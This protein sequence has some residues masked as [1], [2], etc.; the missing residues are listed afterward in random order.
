MGQLTIEAVNYAT[1]PSYTTSM[2]RQPDYPDYET[3]N[4][5]LTSPGEHITGAASISFNHPNVA[6]QTYSAL[7][8]GNLGYDL[9]DLG[10]INSF[11]SAYLYLRV[12]NRTST[13]FF[14]TDAAGGAALVGQNEASRG[15]VDKSINDYLAIYQARGTEFSTRIPWSSIT[16][17][18]IH[19][20]TMNFNASGMSYL[21]SVFTKPYFKG[22][23]Y[24]GLIFGG[25]VDGVSPTVPTTYSCY[26]TAF[27]VLNADLVLNWSGNTG[28]YIN[29]GDS[30]KEVAG[31]LINIG[32]EWKGIDDIDLN[33]G[34]VWKN[35]A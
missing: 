6:T 27:E 19:Y 13:N 24:F 29:I 7:R 26:Q 23:A 25:I 12:R 28:H 32:D 35:K 17:T 15:G 22:Y 16:E 20:Q 8:H 2:W 18:D 5:A 33:V 4:V 14:S 1:T 21:N 11:T 3:W 31:G 34:D 10:F 9:R 30:W